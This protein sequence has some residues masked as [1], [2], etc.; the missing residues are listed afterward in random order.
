MTDPATRQLAFGDWTTRVLRRGDGDEPLILLH[1][2][3]VDA[4][5]WRPLIRALP[6][7]VPVLALDLR[8]QGRSTSERR[9]FTLEMLADDVIAVLG[10]EGVRAGTV[11]GLALG[12]TVAQ[13]VATRAPHLTARLV[14]IDTAASRTPGSRQSLLDRADQAERDGLDELIRGAVPRW[15]PPSV[16]SPEP[17]VLDGLRA[18]MAAVDPG[19]YAA[20]GRAFADLDLGANAAAIA[21]PTLILVGAED[22]AMPPERSAELH[23]LIPQS[24]LIVLPGVGH[25]PPLQE[26]ALIARLVADF[27]RRDDRAA[28]PLWEQGLRTRREVLGA[29]YVDSGLRDADDF[30]MAFQRMTTEWCWGYTWNRPVLDRRTRSLLNL[31]MLTALGKS[32]ELRL[33]VRGA[34]HNGVSV[35]EIREALLHATTYCG[36]PAGLE[37]FRAAHEVL[38]AEGALD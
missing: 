9:P 7:D 19:H 12:G 38:V 10:R 15:F 16:R 35:A 24:E 11:V 34:L 1:S 30:M 2:H 26:P 28:G 37:A 20:M 3:G 8:G 4:D 29:E 33:H 27:A 13:L 6:E 32:A 23:A 36:I 14:L 22:A 21:C 25:C 17:Q 31:V 18:M 5:I